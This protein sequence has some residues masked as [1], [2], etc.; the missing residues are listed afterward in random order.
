MDK[1]VNDINYNKITYLQFVL[2]LMV[3]MIHTYNVDVYHIGGT[4][5]ACFEKEISCISKIAVPTFF[6]ISG[7][8]FFKNYKISETLKK[9]KRRLF[10]IV[11][12]L[13]LW[14]Y[15][16][17]A[18]FLILSRI[19][20]V[21]NNINSEIKP[22]NISSFLLA[23][24]SIEYNKVAWYL[25]NLIV[26]I[27]FAPLLYFIL[28]NKYIGVAVVLGIPFIGCLISNNYLIQSMYFMF[29][30]YIGMH[31]NKFA[32][33][34]SS[35][36]ISLIALSLFFALSQVLFLVKGN[37]TNYFCNFILLLMI[38]SLWIAFDCFDY[39]KPPKWWMTISFFIYMIHSFIL[40]SIE[41][42]ILLML[43][44]SLL[45]SILDYFV[46]PIITLLII[47]L[48]AYYLKKLCK[49]VWN[50]LTGSR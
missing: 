25:V 12:P 17:Y 44:E 18:Y 3:I 28:K 48:L 31:F 20:I 23:G 36:K 47:V 40:E 21:S 8:L 30:A 41:K 7:F 27:L 38:P 37:T 9:W 2:S 13:I 4:V 33:K 42:I 50:L 15:L 29:G 24:F 39:E 16:S 10:S 46:A 43:G 22:L 6:A 45:G 14:N 19:P 11:V 35:C 34:K 5:F 26:Y 1:K 32:Y 49:P